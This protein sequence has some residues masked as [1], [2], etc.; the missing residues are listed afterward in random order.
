MKITNKKLRDALAHLNARQLSTTLLTS[1]L[2]LSSSIAN[3]ATTS[4]AITGD[5]VGEN[6]LDFDG[7]SDAEDLGKTI[8]LFTLDTGAAGAGVT[9]SGTINFDNRAPDTELLHNYA[10]AELISITGAGDLNMNDLSISLSNYGGQNFSS[11]EF[12]QNFAVIGESFTGKLNLSNSTIAINA[13]AGWST[14]AQYGINIA[15]IG[16]IGTDSSVSVTGQSF[17]TRAIFAIYSTSIDSLA[18]SVSVYNTTEATGVMSQK[19]AQ[20]TGSVTVTSSAEDSRARGMV[21]IGN[22]STTHFGTNAAGDNVATVD[23]SGQFASGLYYAGNPLNTSA[24][25]AVDVFGGTYTATS[26]KDPSGN[27]SW[28]YGYAI[29]GQVYVDVGTMKANF[30]ASSDTS[31]IGFV[32]RAS[33]I[34]TLSSTIN[35][36]GNGDYVVG[37]VL[38]SAWESGTHRSGYAK[39]INGSISVENASTDFTYMTAGLVTTLGSTNSEVSSVGFGNFTGEI[40]A[41][42]S[43]NALGMELYYRNISESAIYGDSGLIGGTISAL[44]TD[45]TY[46]V[47]RDEYGD[48]RARLSEPR[49][50]FHFKST[51]AIRVSVPED[52]AGLDPEKTA[53]LNFSDGVVAKAWVGAEGKENGGSYGD[54]IAFATD[55]LVLNAN[56]DSV[57][58]LIGDITSDA[59]AS[60]L[61]EIEAESCIECIPI[62]LLTIPGSEQRAASPP[63]TLVY[64]Q[65]TYHVNSDYWFVN[66]V[67]VGS[68]SNLEATTTSTVHLHDSTH[69]F[70]TVDLTFF[71]SSVSDYSRITIDTNKSMTITELEN[72]Q[73][74]LGAELM[75]T[76]SFRITVID[77]EMIDAM[78]GTLAI[79]LVD[80]ITEGLEGYI[81]DLGSIYVEY[82]GQRVYYTDE[83]ITANGISF[84]TTGAA[85]DLIIGRNLIPEPSTATLSLLA[86]AGLMMRRRRS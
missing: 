84:V 56:P 71:L 79:T 53:V 85:T 57:V 22:D 7:H 59:E 58:N 42:G 1:G 60:P 31:S 50:Q 64:N 25:N 51:T 10:T 48:H 9:I 19:L 39:E 52:T 61:N 27:D 73:L 30:S 72:I 75:S 43:H 41:T 8:Q 49:D 74:T 47:T 37:L 44:S 5:R 12:L 77:G 78:G 2:L 20:F 83:N 28:P 33:T 55:K 17:M 29:A 6:A 24:E 32:Q 54:A 70:D 45:D 76:E 16:T 13:N 35:A 68:S 66:R 65:G 69:L 3:A 11:G 23:A 67:E 62:A 34:D 4:T 18:G 21:I 26:H 46:I 38:D 36:A 86:L 81:D 82:D 14:S 80:L 63:R 15:N 40:N